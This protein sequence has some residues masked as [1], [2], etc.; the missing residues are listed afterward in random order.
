MN[1]GSKVSRPVIFFKIATVMTVAFLL[2]GGSLIAASHILAVKRL[3]NQERLEAEYLVERSR[4]TLKSR[5]K[6][7]LSI[8]DRLAQSKS[9]RAILAANTD[10]NGR[11]D[12]DLIG[13]KERTSSD[14]YDFVLIFEDTG[15]LVHEDAVAVVTAQGLRNAQ[16]TVQEVAQLADQFKERLTVGDRPSMTG[17]F[18]PQSG[19]PVLLAVARVLPQEQQPDASPGLLILGCYLDHALIRAINAEKELT[20]RITPVN[21]MQSLAAPQKIQEYFAS[22]GNDTLITPVDAYTNAGYAQ[23]SDIF[24]HPTLILE[25]NRNRTIFQQGMAQWQQIVTAILAAHCILLLLLL[26]LL[27]RMIFRRL[28]R[29]ALDIDALAAVGH[30]GS[31]VQVQGN[32]EI[33]W[34]AERLNNMLATLDQCQAWQNNNE[35]YLNQVLNSIHSGVMVVDATTRTIIGINASGAAMVGLSPQEITGNIC[36]QFLCPAEL[37]ACPVLDH[38]EQ[39]D[40][41]ERI[42]LRADGKKIPVLKSVAAVDKDG[43]R[44]L[45]ESFID[46][47]KLKQA[48]EELKQSESKYR[49]FFE[50]DLTGNCIWT[51]DSIILDCNPAFALLLGYDTVEAA[52][53]AGMLEHCYTCGQ[54][55][56]LLALLKEK[57]SVERMECTLRH[58]SGMPVHCVANIFTNYDSDGTVKELRGY[59]FDDTKR[60]LLER[61]NHQLGKMDALGALASGLAHEIN[62]ILASIKGNADLVFATAEDILPVQARRAMEDILRAGERA[63]GLTSQVLTFSRPLEKPIQ[64]VCLADILSETLQ[65]L[66]ATLPAT[67]HLDAQIHSQGSTPAGANELHQ[68]IM[69]LCVNAIQAMQVRGGTL[70]IMLDEVDQPP[71]SRLLPEG[72]STKRMLRL[73]IDDTGCGIAPHLVERIFDPFF[74][75]KTKEMGNGLG[76]WL[77]KSHVT[78][79]QGQISLQSQPGQGT[80]FI[81][82][83]PLCNEPQP[84]PAA[85]AHALPLGHEQI[86][87]VDDNPFI[88]EVCTAMLQ[89]LGYS[90]YPFPEADKALA[91]LS[92]GEISVSLLIVSNSMSSMDGFA[93]VRRLRESGFDCP[94]LLCQEKG[95]FANLEEAGINGIL[96]KPVDM[97]QLAKSIRLTLDSG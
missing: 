2:L 49:R 72:C 58:K 77:V 78:A 64:T 17:F 52:K 31:R 40:L 47:S 1:K 68:V 95:D 67:V 88:L 18:L 80:S 13:L 11:I 35:A 71:Q 57:R 92:S 73:R 87:L 19:I 46:I 23:L 59:F 3:Q 42:L 50:E 82:T 93:L 6:R 62:N 66:A 43:S 70:R 60:I 30:A 79:M 97:E 27:H 28:R 69:N 94:V 22:H 85:E 8:A 74:T 38:K 86:A 89:H 16:T 83:F 24:G 4:N 33:A 51:V 96:H 48:E 56:D 37:H 21:G 65:I 76:L 15:R 5:E 41:R 7:L 90:V 55:D 81:L 39:I 12:A 54:R 45:I 84:P 29:L 14:L 75:T 9:L 63:Q 36:H 53:D 25:I 32:D 34:L 20:M 26:I 10:R 44:L 91:T 61:Q